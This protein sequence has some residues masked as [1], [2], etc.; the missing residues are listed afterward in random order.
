M[1]KPK[2]III[3]IIIG[4]LFGGIITRVGLVSNNF[5]KNREIIQTT[6]AVSDR[7]QK[8]SYNLQ[9]VGFFS[10]GGETVGVDVQGDLVFLA[11]ESDGLEIV[12]I[13]DLNS[14]KLVATF[15]VNNASIYDLLVRD[16]FVFLAHGKEGLRIVDFSNLSKIKEVGSFDDGGTAWGISVKDSFAFLADRDQGLEIIDISNISRPTKV[17]SVPGTSLGVVIRDNLAFVAAGWEKGLEII[18]IS[19]PKNPRKIAETFV[20]KGDGVSIFVEHNT[21]FLATRRAGLIIYDISNPNTPK[22]IGQFQDEGRGR[23][24]DVF[25]ED[26]FAFIADEAEGVEIIDISTPSN[27]QE[28]AQFY[29]GG[30]GKAFQILV[31]NQLIFVADFKDGVEILDWKTEPPAPIQGNYKTITTTSLNFNHTI[32]PLYAN[33]SFGDEETRLEVELE[34]TAGFESPI[35]LSVTAP[36]R[37]RAEDLINFR[38]KIAGERSRFW[39][40]LTGSIQ[41]SNSYGISEE[42]TLEAAGVPA[43]FELAAFPTIIGQ[44]ISKNVSIPPITLWEQNLFNTSLAFLMFPLFNITG[45]ATIS[46]KVNGTGQYVPMHWTTDGE[47]ILVPIQIPAIAKK[48]YTISLEEIQFNIEDLKLDLYALRFNLVAQD[49]VPIESW[50]LNLTDFRNDFVRESV[51][52]KKMGQQN[53][54]SRHITAPPPTKPSLLT[55]SPKQESNRSLFYLDGIY[56]LGDFVIVI[57]LADIVEPFPTWAIILILAETMISLSLPWLFLCLYLRVSERARKKQRGF[58]RVKKKG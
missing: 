12:D 3:I 17:S 19:T 33:E 24:W 30:E 15:Q 31:H 37:I 7:S 57:K 25:V 58:Y 11:D 36:E 56:P 52:Q 23:T 4:L 41:Y 9:E 50:Q 16:S 28:V 29:D 18:D 27:P 5:F 14:P 2:R 1:I 21:A 46:A 55:Y 34:L 26:Y 40:S 35:L 48:Q 22:Q 20:E 51:I 47:E 44:D 49:L 8:Q 43:F 32:S 10:N 54:L 42:T 6:P 45:T 13:A 39:A 38:I 53:L